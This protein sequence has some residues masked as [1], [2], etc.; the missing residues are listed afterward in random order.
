MG[1]GTLAPVTLWVSIIRKFEQGN[2]SLSRCTSRCDG[3]NRFGNG[4]E[5]WFSRLQNG[6]KEEEEGFVY[7]CSLVG[8]LTGFF[9]FWVF[10]K[11]L[12]AQEWPEQAVGLT[13]VREKMELARSCFVFIFPLIRTASCEKGGADG[14]TKQPE[15]MA[16]TKRATGTLGLS[17]LCLLFPFREF[18]GV[19]T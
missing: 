15:S 9:P 16:I 1:M 17:E 19:N 4:Q 10:K 13:C 6:V 3:F 18:G 8:S 7:F 5:P 12:R 11:F 2:Y 14:F